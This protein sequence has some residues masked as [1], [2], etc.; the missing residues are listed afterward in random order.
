MTNIG[1]RLKQLRQKSGIGVI[2]AAE[3]LNISRQHLYYLEQG[4]RKPSPI[5]ALKIAK[6]YNCTI[7]EIYGGHYAN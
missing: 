5:L 4:K 6:L 2:E 7:D 1:N 3:Q